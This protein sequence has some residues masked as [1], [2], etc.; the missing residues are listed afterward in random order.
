M[1]TEPAYTSTNY[2][3]GEN[4]QFYLANHSK[5]SSKTRK[6]LD[7]MIIEKAQSKGYPIYSREDVQFIPPFIFGQILK[8]ARA[9]F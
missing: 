1:S 8:D 2:I 9:E 6:T 5:T 3:I 7:Q 4:M